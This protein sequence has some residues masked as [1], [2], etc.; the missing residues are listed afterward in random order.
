MVKI[1]LKRNPINGNYGSRKWIYFLR[2]E[3][4]I[5]L[6]EDEKHVEMKE[7]NKRKEMS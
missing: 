1:E 5:R 6:L 7:G 2:L 4:E 3:E